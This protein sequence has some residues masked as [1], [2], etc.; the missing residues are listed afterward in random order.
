MMLSHLVNEEDRLRA[1]LLVFYHCGINP[2]AEEEAA[3]IRASNRV[4]AK[5]YSYADWYSDEQNRIYLNNERIEDSP[6]HDFLAATGMHDHL[7]ALKHRTMDAK[8]YKALDTE[9]TMWY[10]KKNDLT[11]GQDIVKYENN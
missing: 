7:F 5:A 11:L 8:T 6:L 1:P 4:T 2:P 3:L 9:M 10:A